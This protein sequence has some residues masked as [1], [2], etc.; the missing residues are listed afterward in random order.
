MDVREAA[1][2]LGWKHEDVKSAIEAGVELPKSKHRIMLSATKVGNTYDIDDTSLDEFIGAFEAVEPGRHPPVPVRRLL[3]TEA[4]HKCAICKSSDPLQFHHILEFHK[5][6]HHDSKHMLAVCGSCH[7]RIHN[8]TIDTKS[9][10]IYKGRLEHLTEISDPQLFPL[11]FSWDDLR[12]IIEV[13]H[14]EVATRDPSS[15]SK[16]DFSDTE[17]ER[18]NRLNRL[19]DE[20]FEM[21]RNRYEPY[22]GKIAEFLKDPVNTRVADL[23]Y[24]IVDELRSKIAAAR[25]RFDGFEDILLEVYDSAKA[26]PALSSRR[27]SPRGSGSQLRATCR[28]QQ[29]TIQ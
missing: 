28:T 26:I 22:F 3:L 21:M 17:L 13:I 14:E 23:Y 2:L 10:R 5:L 29:A 8:G 24:E 12:E 16:Y 18:K 6:K 9:L 25:S 27:S 20:Y 11:R 7:S 4:N 1:S 19:G 15:E